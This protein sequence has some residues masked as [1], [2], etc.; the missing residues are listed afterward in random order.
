MKINKI[1]ILPLAYLIALTLSACGSSD[2]GKGTI[3]T[4]CNLTAHHEVDG[5]PMDNVNREFT[6]GKITNGCLKSKGLKPA[7][8][9]SGCLVEPK[10]ADQGDAY[11][12]AT[13]ECWSQ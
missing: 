4:D 10:S 13:Q 6:L 1:H 5:G 7:S 9:K 3:F 12:K 11:V 2:G 8:D